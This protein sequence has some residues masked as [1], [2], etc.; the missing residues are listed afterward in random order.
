M[1]T[2]SYGVDEVNSYS[3]LSDCNKYTPQNMSE[4]VRYQHKVYISVNYCY[5]NTSALTDLPCTAILKAILKFDIK[6]K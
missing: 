5:F 4:M 2:T 3:V 6:I 1:S